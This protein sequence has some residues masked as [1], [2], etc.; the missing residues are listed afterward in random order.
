MLVHATWLCSEIGKTHFEIYAAVVVYESLEQFSEMRFVVANPNE[1]FE[2]L[3]E[4]LEVAGNSTQIQQ[5]INQIIGKL[6]RAKNKLSGEQL[7]QTQSLIGDTAPVKS[8]ELS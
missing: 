7:E 2:S 8:A 6:Q 4:K 1:P 3:L 5:Q